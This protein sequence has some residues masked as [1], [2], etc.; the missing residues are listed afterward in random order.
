M[1]WMQSIDLLQDRIGMVD[2]K[3]FGWFNEPDKET[4]EMVWVSKKLI[5]GKTN[6]FVKV[7]NVLTF[8]EALNR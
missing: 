8:P 4:G 3:S 1:G 5:K 6:E 2:A 7:S